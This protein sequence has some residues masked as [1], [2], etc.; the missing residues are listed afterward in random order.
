MAAPPSDSLDATHEELLARLAPHNQ[1]HV[2]SFWDRLTLVERHNL[3]REVH[4][5]DFE[6]LDQ[7]L[8]I[9]GATSPSRE[10]LEQVAPAPA[11]RLNESNENQEQARQTGIEALRAGQVGVIFVAGGQGSRLGF[12]HPKGMF[13]IGP[14]SNSSLFQ[15][16]FEKLIATSRTYGTSLPLYLMT[17][18][19]THKE[20]V[21]YLSEKNYFGINSQDVTIFS[22]GVMPA[23]DAESRRLLM[24]APDSLFLSP[25]GH[26][27][28]I[29]GML[30]AGV[31]DDMRRRGLRYLFYVQVDN[32][33][34]KVCDPL[35]IGYHILRQ[36]EL[37]TQVVAKQSPDDRLGNVVSIG[38]QVHIIEYSDMPTDVAKEQNADGSLKLWAGSIAVHVFDVDFLRRACQNDVEL[39]WHIAQKAVPHIDE[40]GEIVTPGEPNALKFERFIFDLLP[41]AKNGLVVEVDRQ[42]CFAPVKNAPGSSSDSPQHVQQQMCDL[43][44]RWLK[45]AGAIVADTAVVEISPLAALNESQVSDM[46]DR[47]TTVTDGTFLSDKDKS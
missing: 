1:Q 40:S 36:S 10:L 41:A 27:G 34:T 15:I 5:L 38:S 44:R 17:S 20:T 8:A 13:P 21:D 42:E 18:P 30:N 37:S 9:G 4:G 39:P 35:F 16:L 11:V 47:G 22:Q 33:L 45:Q 32:P 29:A 46:I 3:A 14:V 2:L 28:L 26:G 12:P 7:C 23:V 19:A 43:H 24:A 6:Q 31:I 25:D